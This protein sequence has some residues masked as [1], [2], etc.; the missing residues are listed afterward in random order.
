MQTIFY[1]LL[2]IIFF[3]ITL[4]LAPQA[5]AADFDLYQNQGHKAEKWDSIVKAGFEAFD[6]ND[7]ETST[8]FLQK[9]Y[10]KGCRDGL[11]LF[12]L[13]LNS[14]LNKDYNQA[15]KFFKLAT[16]KLEKQ[17]PDYS[18]TKKIHEHLARVYYQ[19]D[20]FDQALPE[21]ELALK[22]EPDSFMLLFMS[23]Q[24]YRGK[25]NNGQAIEYYE[26][27]LKTNIPKDI[28]TAQQTIWTELMTLYFEQGQLDLSSKYA[29]QILA[30]NPTDPT[31]LSY[32]DA[33][34]KMK[35]KQRE[36]EAIK[37]IVQ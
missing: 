3:T 31:A 29:Q 10:D 2:F 16:Q 37:R 12:K 8:I 14:E 26:K 15:I 35:Y 18:Q 30:F 36:Q 27:A 19:S 24:I 6:A 32:Q 7:L 23:A 4:F 22:N 9:A 5:L 13:G 17:Y 21:L 33:I 28:P 1:K 11:V 25:K 34:Q 20:Q